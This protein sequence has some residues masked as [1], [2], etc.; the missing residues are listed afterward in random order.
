MILMIVDSCYETVSRDAGIPND[1]EERMEVKQVRQ[2]VRVQVAVASVQD[3]VDD[4]D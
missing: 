2:L 1:V 4:E 3:S